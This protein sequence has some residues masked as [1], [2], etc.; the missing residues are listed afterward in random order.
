MPSDATERAAPTRRPILAH[1]HRQA[2]E[3]VTVPHEPHTEQ[4]L[5][6]APDP[7]PWG[8]C[9]GHVPRASA[10]F[11]GCS[12]AWPPPAEGEPR[13]DSARLAEESGWS[14]ARCVCP[15]TALASASAV[16]CLTTMTGRRPAR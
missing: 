3:E 6:D 10:G 8:P 4:A 12:P 5:A 2:D 13:Y 7:E 9:P 16:R 15:G 1:A 11:V 14:T